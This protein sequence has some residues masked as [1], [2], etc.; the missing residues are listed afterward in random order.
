MALLPDFRID[1]DDVTKIM[2][3]VCA[4]GDFAIH[5]STAGSPGSGAGVGVTSGKVKIESAN[6]AALSGA[7]FAGVAFEPHVSLDTT[8]YPL[9]PYNDEHLVNFPCRLATRGFIVTDNIS[10]TP[11]VGAPAYLALSGKVSPTDLGGC[12]QVGKFGTIKDENGFA[13]VDFDIV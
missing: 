13:R 5:V 10:G 1:N 3:T 11:T 6:N 9:N 2:T 4:K 12:P 7:K 8:K